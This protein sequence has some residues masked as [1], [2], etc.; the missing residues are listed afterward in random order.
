MTTYPDSDL[1]H[2]ELSRTACLFRGDSTAEGV[3]PARSCRGKLG[4]L[5]LVRLGRS[6]LAVVVLHKPCQVV[7][8][9]PSAIGLFVFQAVVYRN[10]KVHFMSPVNDLAR[11]DT[12]I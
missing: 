11:I 8:T 9:T 7:R 2:R 10:N 3:E 4:H 1:S 5:V 6:G 12:H